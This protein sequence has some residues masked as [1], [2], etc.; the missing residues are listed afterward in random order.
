NDLSALL[1]AEAAKLEDEEKDWHPGSNGQVLDLVHPSLY[2]IMYGR[3]TSTSHAQIEPPYEEGWRSHHDWHSSW[4]P[5]NIAMDCVSQ[6]Y[7]WLPSDF[8]VSDEH[9]GTPEV[10]LLSPYINNL[11][12]TQHGGLYTIIERIV[13][14]FIPMF[15]RVLSQVNGSERDLLRS[16]Q[17]DEAPGSGRIRMHY[18]HG[19]FIGYEMKFVGLSV[20]CIWNGEMRYRKQFESRAQYLDA[21]EVLPEAHEKDNG[22][23]QKSI[24]P[25]SLRGKTIQCIIKLA[26][27]HLTPEN[28]DYPG[29]SWHVEGML[30]ERIVASGIYYYDEENIT[31]SRL[32]FRVTTSPPVYHRQDDELCSKVL[33]GMKRK[34]HCVQDIGSIETKSGRALVWPNIYQ[35]RVRV[36]PFSLKDPS[37]PGHRKILAIFLV[38]PSIEPIPSATTVPPQQVNWALVAMEEAQRDPQSLVSRLPPE[39]VYAICEELEHAGGQYLGRT[40]AEKTRLDLMAERTVFVKGRRRELMDSFHMCEH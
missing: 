20:P 39:L 28:K 10:R 7:S 12:P 11:H 22:A 17:Q 36:S 26:N 8:A 4:A 32:A 24:I 21:I 16:W 18:K 2:P 25:Y 27:I 30:N 33:Y 6:K 15:E 9:D 31:E 14:A 5:N 23:L 13:G 35:H 3:T 40:E 29:G 38:D 37:R 19:I 34:S 1:R